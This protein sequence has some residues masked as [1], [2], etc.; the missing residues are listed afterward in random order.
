MPNNQ[1]EPATAPDAFPDGIEF[2]DSPHGK[3]AQC[4]RCGG[5]VEWVSC[6]N[7]EDGYSHHDC[8]EDCC[9][10]LH[11]VDNVRC[12]WC[13]GTGCAL[14]CLNSPAWCKGNPLPGR[15][16]VESTALN[17]EAWADVF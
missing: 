6:P 14:H 3:E 1:S 7:C 5:G 11:P 9:C 15:E 10:C 8:G 12:D 17:A 2:F 4:A 13:G 16:H